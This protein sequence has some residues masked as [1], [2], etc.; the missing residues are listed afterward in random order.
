M[1]ILGFLKG[2]G[3][4]ENSELPDIFPLSVD[5]VAF[6]KSDIEA[7]YTK[8]LTDT[9]ERTH[10]I[11][12]EVVPMLWDNCLQNE[13]QHGLVSLLVNA[14]VNQSDLCIVYKKA[15]KVLRKATFEEQEKIKKDYK[16]SGTSKDGV[17]ISFRNYHRTDMLKIY[18]ALEYCI[19]TSLHKTVNIS[20]AVQIKIDS[21]RSSISLA[22]AGVAEAQARSLAVALKNGCDV[23]LDA[24]DEITTST[25]DVSPTEKAIG[26]LDAKRAFYLDL[27]L[28]Y[29]SG[30]QTAGIGATGE[31]DTKAIERGLKQYF[32]SIIHPVL[33]ALFEVDTEFKSQ[34]FRQI[35]S[36]LETLKTFELVSDTNLSQA[37]K[38]DILARMFDVDPEEEQAALEEEAKDRGSDT[39]LNGA[40]V[41]AMSQFLAQLATGQLAPDTAIQALIVSFNLTR[42]DAEAIVEPMKT[43]KPKVVNT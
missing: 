29:I 2:K 10:G 40:Q 4:T 36:A 18:S 35:T 43:F 24:K 25:P 26:F 42:E 22:D 20:K 34:D 33:L 38:R 27:P 16:D 14:M 30:L 11:P 19:L 31:A 21:L 5:S 32:F 13:T 6:I 17:F 28:S 9:L 1:N 12:K 15:L 23:F 8:I 41:T 39:S 37:S 7:T 3:A